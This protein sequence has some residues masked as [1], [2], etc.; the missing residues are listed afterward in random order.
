LNAKKA[1][2]HDF[3]FNW[4]RATKYESDILEWKT[5]DRVRY[6]HISQYSHC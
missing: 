4:F 5:S 3:V 6:T 1:K 2:S